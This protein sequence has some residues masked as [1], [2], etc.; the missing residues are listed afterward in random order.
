MLGFP[1]LVRYPDVEHGGDG[2]VGILAA[3]Q[4][5]LTDRLGLLGAH[6]RVDRVG[7][8]EHQPLARMIE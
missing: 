5:E 6:H 7:V 4:V 2:L 8:N 1:L 3:E